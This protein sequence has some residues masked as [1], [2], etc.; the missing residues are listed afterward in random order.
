MD[1][2]P[3]IPDPGNRLAHYRDSSRWIDLIAFLAVLALGGALIALSGVSIASVATTVAALGWL[4][5]VWKHSRPTRDGDNV[6]RD[7]GPPR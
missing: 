1:Q 4:Y 2:L 7:D 3:K 6:G 5:G